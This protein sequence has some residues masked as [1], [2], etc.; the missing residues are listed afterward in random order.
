MKEYFVKKHMPQFGKD[1]YS[2]I[3][4]PNEIVSEIRADA[5]D[6]V[7]NKMF[8]MPAF[9]TVND[10]MKILDELKEQKNADRN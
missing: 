6:E 4:I 7:R 1:I 5:I 2:R 8:S 10:V 3:P 9:L